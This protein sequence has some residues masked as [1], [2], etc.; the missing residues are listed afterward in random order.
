MNFFLKKRETPQFQN[1]SMKNVQTMAKI[2]KIKYEKKTNV[3]P[4]ILEA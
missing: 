2:L 4:K 3:Q 1:T